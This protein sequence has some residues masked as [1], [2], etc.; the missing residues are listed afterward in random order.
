MQVPG[1]YAAVEPQSHHSRRRLGVYVQPLQ[2]IR[3]FAQAAVDL[4]LRVHPLVLLGG[5]LVLYLALHAGRYQLRAYDYRSDVSVGLLDAAGHVRFYLGGLQYEG[6]VLPRQ[7]GQVKFKSNANEASC[8]V[9]WEVISW[10]GV[11]QPL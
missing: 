11:E 5:A 8:T 3:V 1:F 9:R 2:K 4:M 10:Q 6:N 7:D